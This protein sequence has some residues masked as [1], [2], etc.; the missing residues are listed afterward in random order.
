[1][2]VHIEITVSNEG[3]TVERAVEYDCDGPKAALPAPWA[4]E[5]VDMYLLIAMQDAGFERRGSRDPE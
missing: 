4:L 1:M 5:A 2:R 3:E